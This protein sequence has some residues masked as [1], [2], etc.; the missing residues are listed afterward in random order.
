MNPD[1]AQSVVAR[2]LTD[3]NFLLRA[4]DRT[5][6]VIPGDGTAEDIAAEILGGVELE[7][8]R[9]FRGFITKVKH[10]ALRRRIPATLGLM[11][12][13]GVE[14]SFFCDFSPAYVAARQDGPL[15]TRRHLDL[16]SNA[17][18]AFLLEQPEETSIPVAETFEHEYQIFDL[19]EGPSVVTETAHVR[20]RGAMTLS[21]R[22]I[23]VIRICER[24]AL[25]NFSRDDI[26]TR[27]HVLFY[28]R[29]EAVESVSIHEVD[30]LTAAV[31]TALRAGGGPEQ[32]R[33]VLA[34]VG[35]SKVDAESLR[36]TAVAIAGRGF[37]E[38]RGD[39]L[40]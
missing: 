4:Y 25:R 5:H 29:P 31:F 14:L 20:W 22:S 38:L 18:S 1:Q 37:L 34:D 10:N 15:G 23:D 27:P 13:L 26:V 40:R 12:A 8:L 32:T 19:S 39:W 28:W 9:R 6:S 36:A 7:R 24:L 2:C 21:R 3:P 11:G 35:L 16:F 33:R 17:L 30:A